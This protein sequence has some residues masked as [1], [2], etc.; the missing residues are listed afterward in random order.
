[1]SQLKLY[2]KVLELYGTDA[3]WSALSHDQQ[4]ERDNEAL[5]V[6]Q[7]AKAMGQL[8]EVVAEAS[9]SDSFYLI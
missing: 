8:P 1:M 3:E 4:V 2:R 7:E 5:Q 9:V 6:S